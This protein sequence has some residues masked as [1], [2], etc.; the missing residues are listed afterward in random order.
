M[1]ESLLEEAKKKKPSS[2]KIKITSDGL[3]D[4][5]KTVS[6]AIPE[7]LPVATNIAKMISGMVV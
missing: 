4:A 3:L 1:T 6:K 2:R 7:I 5:A